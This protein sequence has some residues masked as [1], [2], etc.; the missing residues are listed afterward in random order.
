M[1]LDRFLFGM[2]VEGQDRA[3]GHVIGLVVVGLT[4][5]SGQFA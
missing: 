2:G 5:F 4:R 3:L 1:S